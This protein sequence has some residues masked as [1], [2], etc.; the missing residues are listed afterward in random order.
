M[1]EAFIHRPSVYE[2]WWRRRK[3]GGEGAISLR[4]QSSEMG[5]SRRADATG[6]HAPPS[7]NQASSLSHPSPTLPS[8]TNLATAHIAL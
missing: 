4:T 2:S 6:G 7:A 3:V 1:A 5:G 8:R